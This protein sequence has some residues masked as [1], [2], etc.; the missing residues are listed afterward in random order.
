MKTSRD[1]D[2]VTLAHQFAEATR[3]RQR[4]GPWTFTEAM[5]RAPWGSARADIDG[6]HES[7]FR[8]AYAE[9]LVE[10]GLALRVGRSR[11]SGPAVSEESRSERGQGRVNLR[12]SQRALEKLARLATA[13]GQSQAGWVEAAVLAAPEP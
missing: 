3:P 10:R 6:E 2:A 4:G 1:A 9:Q 12:L 8:R 11:T 7:D 13:A 5:A